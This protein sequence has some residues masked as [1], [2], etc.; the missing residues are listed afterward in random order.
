MT[1]PQFFQIAI[2]PVPTELAPLMKSNR[3]YAES[4]G[5]DY[6]VVTSLDDDL[7]AKVDAGELTA[8]NA[9]DWMRM[10]CLCKR[11]YLVYG[12]WDT[13]IDGELS[14][15]E[16]P[17]FFP[18]TDNFLYNGNR[19]DIFEELLERM[20][21]PRNEDGIIHHTFGA[22]LRD[23]YN[24]F[25]T[26]LTAQERAVFVS[27]HCEMPSGKTVS[28][29]EYWLFRISE[30]GPMIQR[31]SIIKHYNHSRKALQEKDK[32]ILEVVV[33]KQIEKLKKST[34]TIDSDGKK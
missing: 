1:K 10:R 31:K 25:L 16:D 34:D 21:E 30:F 28:G 23:K 19:V 13:K 3:Q 26:E 2:G 9:S 22:L 29:Y 33:E 11:G 32:V 17:Q 24:Q 4:R 14:I 12:D 18:F 15:G 6:V 27:D 5:W 20:G 7:Q 8:R